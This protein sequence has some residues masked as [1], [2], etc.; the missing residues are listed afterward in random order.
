MATVTSFKSLSEQLL[1]DLQ[2]LA[3]ESK[4]RSSD[5]KQACEKSIEILK[6]SHSVQDLSRHPDFV[7]PFISACMSGNAKLTSISMQSL[8]RISGIR[9]VF[10]EK[11]G[12][13]LGALL[14]ATELAIDIQLKVLQLIPNLFKTYA[15]IITGK[16]LAR[17]F[18]CCTQLLQQPNRTSV[19]LGTV[20]ATLQQLVN[21]VFDRCNVESDAAETVTVPIA[22]DKLISVNS[23]RNDTHIV[24]M[25]L[26]QLNDPHQY[27]NAIIDVKHVPEDCVLEILEFVLSNH[28]S[29]ICKFE[30]L[31]YVLRTK[32]VPLLLR[33]FS[34]SKSFPIVVRTARCANLL[35]STQFF[36]HLE[37]ELEIMLWLLV[38]TLSKESDSPMWKS[39]IS[40]EIF[41][42]STKDPELIAKIF[43][44]YD[45]FED[46]KDICSSLL[47]EIN[48]YVN[49]PE[50][51]GIL[52]ES[53]ILLKGDTLII[54]PDN[55]T[56]RVS[57]LN[58]LDKNTPPLIDQ[59]YVV[60]L[61]LSISNNFSDGIGDLTSSNDCFVKLEQSDDH[62]GE[63]HE[64]NPSKGADV[65]RK[66]YET[67]YPLLF[68]IHK[69]FLYSTT[70]DTHLFHS[71]V[72]AIQMLT[73]AS[74]VLGFDDHLQECLGLFSVLIIDNVS[75]THD[76][77]RNSYRQSSSQATS[78]G[79]VLG[80]IGDTLVNVAAN[81]AEKQS[82]SAAQ[83]QSQSQS[84][85]QA[86]NVKNFHPRIF[87]Q[88]NL[89]LFRAL[90]SL[91]IS[92]G[93]SFDKVCWK[94]FFKTWQWVSYYMYGPTTDYM[95]TYY[96]QANVPA[97]TITKQ[98]LSAYETSVKKFTESST[99]FTPSSLYE[100]MSCCIGCSD[101]VFNSSDEVS[102]TPVD[103]TGLS[104]FCPYNQSFF[105][106][107]LSELLVSNSDKVLAEGGDKD[108]WTLF[109]E[110]LINQISNR[111]LSGSTIRL[112]LARIYS[113]TVVELSTKCSTGGKQEGE[114][115][116]QIQGLI[117][118]SLLQLID[119]IRSLPISSESVYSN[120]TNIE[121]DI[122]LQALKTLN[123]LLNS[124]GETLTCWDIVLKILNS[125]FEVIDNGSQTIISEEEG[126][127]ASVVIQK[128][129]EMIQMS[130]EVFK[131]ISDNFLQY[132][133]LDI[134]KSLI[135]TLSHFVSQDRDLNISF[136][137]I[138][139]FWLIA[140][141]L[142]MQEEE[143]GGDDP[144]VTAFTNLVKE[145]KVEDVI[146]GDYPIS[147]KIKSLW[148][149]LLVTLVRCAFD[150]RPEVKTGAVQTFFGIL[151]SNSNF[152]P[153]WNLVASQ[154]LTVLLSFELPAASANDYAE[155]V[156][157]TFKGLL[158]VYSKHL[159]KN[160]IEPEITQYWIN[161]ASKMGEL[162]RLTAYDVVYSV[163]NNF[164]Q[165][166][167]ISNKIDNFP[168]VI[169]NKYYEVWTTYTVMY[170][171]I[172]TND[173]R[174]KTNSDCLQAFADCFQPLYEIHRK[175]SLLDINFIE[176]C[177]GNINAISRYPL[178]PDHISDVSKPS[179]LQKSLLAALCVF[180]EDLPVHF[181][182][183][184]LAQ[185]S[186]IV[187]LPF[188]T[189][190]RIRKKLAAKL[191]DSS[192][193]KIPSFQAISYSAAE[194][195][196]KRLQ[197]L[198]FLDLDMIKSKAFSK[199]LNNL[200]Q[201]M[202]KNSMICIKKEAG[203]PV[204]WQLACDSF[205]LL[206]EK[207][208]EY[209]QD[210]L[211]SSNEENIKE[212]CE[213]LSNSIIASIEKEGKQEDPDIG[214]QAVQ[215]YLQ[216]KTLFIKCLSLD[217]LT[218]E[219]IQ[220]FG[221]ALWSSS[222]YYEIDEVEDAVI[223][224]C[225]SLEDVVNRF[226]TFDFEN[227]VGSTKEP[228]VLPNYELTTTCLV[229][230][231]GFCTLE[232]PK[233]EKIREVCFSFMIARVSFVLRKFIADQQLLNLQPI[234]K[235]KSFEL[236][237]VSTGVLG[238]LKFYSSLSNNTQDFTL[239]HDLY[240][241]LLKAIPLSEKVSGLQETLLQI[242][243]LYA[244]LR[245]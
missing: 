188:D 18:Q 228:A 171:S 122:I 114:T 233:S 99:N 187:D 65:L 33:I 66:L 19:L 37:L 235:V 159:S 116:L 32:V 6:R 238:V 109:N 58:T 153:S 25:N 201:P 126:Q 15:D 101:D 215:I 230:L 130:F 181:E 103:A 236:Q 5:I 12:A 74:G 203:N 81:I 138:S 142:R 56:T 4:R 190:E 192:K 178:L 30:D 125:P 155:F 41:E 102:D 169:V 45:I 137:S 166:L 26:S 186:S 161:L 9:C 79:T 7:D 80:S 120:N 133:P 213:V 16:L 141:C 93:T 164:K 226:S 55:N 53:D 107:E 1:R 121:S 129:K 31:L 207:M 35:I 212:Y 146:N 71:L 42:N 140:D 112:Y 182:L 243:L 89:N 214:K 200:S 92:L 145:G 244:R 163:C 209:L 68:G 85:S 48:T 46:R 208:F 157:L 36:E 234:S 29:S 210:N 132:L 98:D 77:S 51:E 90:V 124:F 50:F 154:A 100:L 34:S 14:R 134:I 242:A 194:I 227:I 147:Q 177:L 119:K 160:F 224:Q 127:I 131:L 204:L 222:F 20:S 232:E 94:I 221:S 165:L 148:I 23:Y 78:S 17:L 172:P 180:D 151:D 60:F 173:Y 175:F 10:P 225:S 150:I 198:K 143:A 205:S 111:S 136:S 108:I 199:L 49:S 39:I 21:E 104:H 183:L 218:K 191:G 72:R 206:S 211:E 96:G 70:L 196:Y 91:S 57:I 239:L 115:S 11:I 87:H 61:L 219:M 167:E 64:E 24:L 83:S 63:S 162:M 149:Y 2:T 59:T 179:P 40:F 3:S 43:E 184:V 8:Q 106:T 105:V 54:T 245:E 156:N 193:T 231:I 110:Y 223:K 62:K 22:N 176:K 113:D 75:R 174:K 47:S 197:G 195:L 84:Q 135:D 220:P 170:T 86:V 241:L 28:S 69:K 73:L 95:E 123:D 82:G 139:Q 229:D 237:Q 117:M 118:R 76:N 52:N 88:R 216:L 144:D 185:L 152:F 27:D 158:Q 13:L 38:H 240:P 44:S 97:A 67:S 189:R 168:V 202:L 217:L 128:H